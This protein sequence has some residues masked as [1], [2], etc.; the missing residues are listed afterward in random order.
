MGDD[1]ALD[2]LKERLIE[3]TEGNPFFLEESVHA[4]VETETLIGERGAYRLAKDLTSMQVPDSVQAVLAARVDRL[5]AAAKHV[6]QVASVIGPEVPG[7][8]L[9]AV[10]GSAEPALR[11]S[12]THL[13]ATEFL[14]ETRLV[15]EPVYTFKHVLTQEAAYQALLPRTRQVVHAQ[16]AQVVAAHFPAMAEA[17]PAR[18]AHHYTEAGLYAQAIPYWQRAGQHALEHSATLEAV[19]HV[20]RGLELLAMLPETPA[21]AQQEL[22]LLVA[23]GPALIA[24]KGRAAPEVEQTYSRA[25]TLGAQVGDT[26]QLIPTLRGLCEFYRTRGELLT[27][28]ELGEQLLRLA[29]RTGAPTPP[30]EAHDALGNTLFFLG[31]Y[32][33][34][35][36][37]L[38]QGMALTDAAAQR[39]RA[40]HHAVAPGV[41]CL[42]VVANTL[43]CLGYP[44]Q[45]MRRGQEAL[46]LSQA[47]AHPYSLA[48][49]QYW[50][51]L[52][53]HH[54]REAPA[55]QAQAE[56]LL[57][58]A[59]AQGFPLWAGFG[60]CWRGW[61]LAMQ[62]QGAA[63]LAL[64][65]QGMTAIL[66]TGQELGRPFCLLLLA[67]A[68]GHAGQVEEGLCLLAEALPASEAGRRGDL[69]VEAYRLQGE[70]LLRQAT[71]G[72][73]Q[74]E[75]CF[76]QA[77][78]IAHHQQAKSWELRVA[79]SLSRLWQQ[80][81]KREEARH[82]LAEIYGW[83]TEGFDTAD[84]REAKALLQ[85]LS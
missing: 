66:A 46:A 67:E 48:V 84:L 75:A 35:R 16:I 41:R 27:A 29:Q 10:L 37:H 45:A 30:L 15:P 53:H 49:A 18:L 36:T 60:T 9:Q 11:E 42:A 34:A 78:A 59:T 33:A 70:F 39:A 32:T 79:M 38:E 25:R 40:F 8:L 4:L 77:L 58:L 52:L 83:F 22:N 80:Q 23:L 5:P 21:R 74:A 47:L 82:L 14:Y 43:W 54:C 44:A 6:V 72:T 61:A 81:G 51:A 65:H 26:P 31:D 68:A 1:A 69:L 71:P 24:T 76:H 13:Q 3:R 7:P 20:T 62:G 19:Q 50:A 17:Q 85:E 64:L 56:A 73:A 2:P 28:R 63:G 57:T 12:L 55:V